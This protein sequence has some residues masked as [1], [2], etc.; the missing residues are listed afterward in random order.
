M[1]EI[2]GGARRA[3]R[4]DLFEIK[5][6]IPE[7]VRD[8]EDVTKLFNKYKLVPF[9]GSNTGTGHALL[10][11]YLMLAQLSPTNGACIEKLKKYVVGSRAKYVRAQDPEF[12]SGTET[13]PMTPAE[14]ATYGQAIADVIEY[15]N[16]VR[17]FHQSV[18][19]SFL[20][21]G[22][23]FVELAIA[24]VNGKFRA[25]IRYVPVTHAI[26]KATLPGE[27]KVLAVSPVWTD[28][29]LTKNEPAMIP[30]APNFVETKGVKRT[31]FHLKAGEN[32]WYGRPESQSA[33][34]YKYREVQ[35]AMY[36]IKQS[37][38][39]FVGQLIIEVEDDEAGADAID[40]NEAQRSGFDSFADRMEYNYTQKGDDPQAVFVTARPVGSRPMFVFQVK[41]NT[42]ENWYK[43]TGESSEQK[44][45]RAHM[46]TPRFMGFDVSNGFATDAFIGDYV[47]NVQPVIDELR[48][49]LMT[50]SNSILS[51]IWDV[52]GRPELNQYSLTFGSP[53]D[54]E[55][56]EYKGKQVNKANND[57]NN[58][59]AV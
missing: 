39:N 4:G 2:H 11:W 3:K 47:M 59:N 36:V 29:Y 57:P 45:L 25:S 12:D 17:K 8:S 19:A 53:I 56:Q 37:A 55:V 10:Y 35:D 30:L 48:L 22:N 42:N 24:E 31:M 40:N 1:N 52:I 18:E 28:K 38:A 41:P 7:E 27:M 33:D 32:E 9:A 13:Q 26:Y 34:L 21:T 58:N 54:G 20:K 49:T 16:G 46:L 14:S 6:P 51:L 5:N 44:I 43:V 15:K 50:F 23:A